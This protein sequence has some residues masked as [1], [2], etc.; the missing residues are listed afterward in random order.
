MVHLPQ[1][2]IDGKEVVFDARH[3]PPSLLDFFSA[4]MLDS[5]RPLFHQHAQN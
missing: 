4:A 2:S 5:T 3:Y 1:A